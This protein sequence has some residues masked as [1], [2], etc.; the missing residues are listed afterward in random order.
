MLISRGFQASIL[1]PLASSGDDVFK[2]ENSWALKSQQEWLT[3]T[4]SSAGH[5]LHLRLIQPRRDPS[6]LNDP[7]L[8]GYG[9]I[10]RKPTPLRIRLTSYDGH[11]GGLLGHDALAVIALKDW[12]KHPNLQKSYLDPQNHEV[13][14]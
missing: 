5:A 7:E 8:H 6:G 9:L 14:C 11:K 1:R 13:D 10:V 2:L 3:K 12:L 4:P